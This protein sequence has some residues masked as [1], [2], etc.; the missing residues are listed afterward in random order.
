M[1]AEKL[2]SYFK[3]LQRR[4]IATKKALQN[5]KV[6]FIAI[7][8]SHISKRYSVPLQFPPCP[9]SGARPPHSLVNVDQIREVDE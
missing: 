9:A 4:C 7:I 5:M 3:Y 1:R 2:K 6:M 8:Q